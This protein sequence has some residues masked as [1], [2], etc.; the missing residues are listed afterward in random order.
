MRLLVSLAAT[1]GLLGIGAL[2]DAA[3]DESPDA[4]EITVAAAVPVLPQPLRDFFRAHL[5]GLV[6][7]ATAGLA[8]ASAPGPFPGE[9]T[10][11]YVGLDIAAGETDPS[12]RAAAARTFPRDRTA[13]TTL[14][15]RRRC[16]DGGSLPWV[17]QER[18]KTL[19]ETFRTGDAQGIVRDAGVLLHFA[20][21]AALPFNTTTDRDG[22][23]TGHLRWSA[24]GNTTLTSLVHRTIRHRCQLGLLDRFRSRLDYEVRVAPQRYAPVE[25]P[26]DAVFPVLLDA[27]RSLDALLA[28]D[29]VTIADLGITGARTFMAAS[30]NYYDRFADQAVQVI[31]T[32]LEAGALLAARLIG[33]AW[34]KAGSPTSD[35]WIVPAAAPTSGS[36]SAD[37]S[38]P[39]F[40]GS[41]HSTVFHQVGCSHA[42][43]IKPANKVYFEGVQVAQDAGRTP[44]KS[45]SPTRH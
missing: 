7:N 36:E 1:A 11:H 24:D 22:T 33:S 45:C 32:R 4:Y 19:V 31:E 13:A 37:Q 35:S 43:R 38:P 23:G 21:D 40:V 25:N 30:G 28:L 42:K 3:V 39:R 8:S 27:H 6:Q 14:F 34:V 12:K 2:T 44:C 18:Y 10:W 26:I 5:D 29:A 41:R 9:M 15:K 17:I 20:T 16:S